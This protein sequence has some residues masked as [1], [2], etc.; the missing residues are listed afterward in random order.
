MSSVFRDVGLPDTLDSDRDT[1]FT[2]EF[3]T[4]LHAALG[5]SL[6][7]RVGPGSPDHHN[8]N[9]RTERVNALV[10]DVLPSRC[11]VDGRQAD[12]PPKFLVP[13]VLRHYSF[14]AVLNLQP[15]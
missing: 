1:R 5:T 9:S 4:A 6:I 8:T 14:K 3:W 15:A 12:W 2:S 7:F 13:K 10:A 11:F